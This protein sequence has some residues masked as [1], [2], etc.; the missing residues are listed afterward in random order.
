MRLQSSFEFII[1]L[2]AVVAL[3]T[4]IFGVYIKMQNSDYAAVS[5]FLSKNANITV[6]AAPLMQGNVSVSIYTPEEMHIGNAS[7]VLSLFSGGY[8]STILNARLEAT[9]A[10]VMPDSYSNVPINGDYILSYDVVPTSTG[11]V[12]V[13]LSANISIGNTVQHISKSAESYSLNSLAGNASPNPTYSAAISYVYDN[14]VYNASTPSG[15]YTVSQSSHC[16]YT[17]WAGGLLNLNGQCGSSATWD[18]FIESAGCYY[19]AGTRYRAYCMYKNSEN[20]DIY[21]VSQVPKYNYSIVLSLDNSSLSLESILDSTKTSNVIVSVDGSVYGNAAV[22]GYVSGSGYSPAPY[23]IMH[24]GSD[25]PITSS[26]YQTYSQ[27][28]NSMDSLLNYYNGTKTS[29]SAGAAMSESINSFNLEMYAL[30]NSNST[31]TNCTFS[32]SGLNY[33]YICQSY[34]GFQF[35]NITAAI[36]GYIGTESINVEGSTINLR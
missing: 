27:Y 8:N 31:D 11:Y 35:S 28:L 24:K 25:I 5:S 3:S 2:G 33:V 16:A 1:L 17:G 6:N 15:M 29:D 21:N 26:Q 14:L 36:N 22:S 34:Q 19:G 4:A 10:V 30:L 13:K 9:N 12:E 32:P 23:F 18:Y 20:A 7:S